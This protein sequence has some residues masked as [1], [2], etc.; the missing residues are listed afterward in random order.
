MDDS[1]PIIYE[2]DSEDM[3]FGSRKDISSSYI[4][5]NPFSFRW[6]HLFLAQ[7]GTRFLT[8]VHHEA[9]DSF[10]RFYIGSSESGFPKHLYSLALEKSYFMIVIIRHHFEGK[11]L[12]N[13]KNYCYDILPILNDSKVTVYFVNE[14][15]GIDEKLGD[16]SIFGLSSFEDSSLDFENEE[17]I[18]LKREE[19][20]NGD[21]D[22]KVIS[23]EID[24]ENI[25]GD[26]DKKVISGDKENTEVLIMKWRNMERIYNNY[27]KNKTFF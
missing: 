4:C 25:E 19:N 21:I 5:R 3:L 13:Y 9:K 8:I 11:S 24:K 16:P 7:P 20:I 15:I 1:I 27:S 14:K 12:E 2:K 18:P 23:E 10:F 22:K 17:K 26:I 6:W